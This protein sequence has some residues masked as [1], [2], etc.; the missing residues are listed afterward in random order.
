MRHGGPVGSNPLPARRL[1]EAVE[2]IHAVVY[3]APEAAAAARRI[4][5]RGFWMSYFAGRVAPLGPVP[6]EPV[7]AMVY[8]FAPTMVARAIPDAWQFAHPDVVVDAR[9]TG[10]ADALRAHLDP[11]SLARLDKLSDLL[12]EAVAGCGFEGRPLASAWS[13]VPRP[14]DVVSSAWLA[15]TIL[16]EHRGDGHVIAAVGA[17]LSG[18][19]ATLT[20]VATGAVTREVMQPNRGWSDD[21]WERSSRRL[22]ARDLLDHAGRLTESGRALRG[23][24]EELTDRLATL[25]IEQLGEAGVEQ[26]I[27]LAAPMSRQLIDHGTIPVPNPV[28]APRP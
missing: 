27:G 20:F 4:G 3:F 14:A 19:D 11:P 21:D 26:A 12:W 24:V 17:G 6:P 16:R 10:A 2:P 18:L 15:M 13:Q 1:W 9:V 23:G 7:A 8:G 28:G 22:R 25:P 5:L